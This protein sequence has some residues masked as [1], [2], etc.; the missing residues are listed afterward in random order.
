[1]NSFPRQMLRQILAKYGKDIC[2]NA[3]RCEGL[4]NDLCGSHRREINVLINAL[5]ERIPLDLLAAANSVP[6]EL[7]LTRLERRL[8]EQTGLTTEAARWAVESWALALGAATDTEIEERGRK[9]SNQSSVPRPEK[10]QPAMS[11]NIP[12][13]QNASNS[14]R[15]NKIQPPKTGTQVPPSKSS[16]PANRQP[17]KIPTPSP[18]VY[19]PANNQPPIQAPA[20]NPQFQPANPV[21]VSK[22]GFG[23]FR[24]CLI[25]IFLLIVSSV[26]ILFVVPYAFEAMR[27]T[28]RERNNEPPRF[29]AR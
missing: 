25:V 14:N 26:L 9:Q 13:N 21:V 28:Q 8:E 20:A 3:R 27:E 2:S 6:Q 15:N 22:G 24:G 7:L 1:M 19:T 5:E 16:S 4:L 12:T 23:I 18:P 17:T 29:P 10:I 11:E